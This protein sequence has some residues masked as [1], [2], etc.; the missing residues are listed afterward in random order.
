MKSLSPIQPQT[1][2]TELKNASWLQKARSASHRV[3]PLWSLKNFVA[4]N[5]FVGLVDRPFG[6]VCELIKRVTH[7]S[8]LMDPAWFKS[9]FESGRISRQDLLEAV[10]AAPTSKHDEKE[11]VVDALLRYL[12]KPSASESTRLKVL[13]VSDI[14]DQ[15]HGAHW[16]AAVNEEIAKW[17]AA[18]FDEGQAAWRMPWQTGSLFSAW[19]EAAVMDASMEIQGLKEFREIVES[20]PAEAPE[21]ITRLLEELNVDLDGAED[22]FHRLFMSLPGWSAFV[23]WRVREKAIQGTQNDMM[24][25]LLAIRL[26]Y[27][28]A[29]L[30]KYEPTGIREFWTGCFANESLDVARDTFLHILWHSALERSFQRALLGKLTEHNAEG[31]SDVKVVQAVQAVFCID[32]RSEVMRRSLEAVSPSLE[33]LGFAGFFGLAIEYIPFGKR[34]GTSQC[35]VLLSP[36]FRVK[37]R[38]P[39]AS[40]TV[41]ER[42]L[43]KQQLG[44]RVGHSWRSFKD[45]AV[46]CFSF[47]ESAG[48]ASGWKLLND[49]FQITLPTGKTRTFAPDLNPRVQSCDK[50]EG[51]GLEVGI[52]EEDQV[53]LA[54]GALKNMGLTTRFARLILLCGHGS[55]TKN[56]PY[57]SGLDCGACGGHSGD[58]NARVGAAI[59]NR[60]VVRAALKDKHGICIPERTVFLSGLHDTTT[61]KITLFDTGSVPHSHLDD[62]RNL[63]D[64][65]HQAS[66]LTRQKRSAML[67]IQGTASHRLNSTFRKRSNDWSQVRP[68]WGL[69]GNAAFIAAPRER[70]KGLDLGGRVFLHNYQFEADTTHSTLELIM[71]APMI[72][73]SWINMQYY[74][75]TV[76]NAQW[77]SGNK[78]THNV[79]GTHGVCQGNTGD[80]KVGLPLQSL[81]DG[82]KWIHE[83]LRLTV[84]L[85]A[86]REAI[87]G[88]IARNENV[89]HL[90]DNG[91]LHLLALEEGG[92]KAYRY[93][94]GNRWE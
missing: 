29:L 49:T 66:D 55:N 60:A 36:Q 12:E 94:S 13:T 48:I 78:V 59:L 75:S 2:A 51:S 84:I 3:P 45:S 62:L 37:E 73:A 50:A 65:L 11:R 47:V 15:R 19:G 93:A 61:D 7:D 35:P 82:K 77:G 17:C 25:D 43:R 18:Y 56:N 42:H 23:Q 16:S 72:V 28:L 54:F 5:P 1:S 86:P 32:V 85:E 53:K 44:R 40:P 88:V 52:T 14:V 24:L 80:L 67:G 63:K 64:W 39:N 41:E 30:R 34:Q 22:Y 70:T 91:W 6:E 76:N 71:T 20:L 27:E 31:K 38:I 26:T 89:R 21:A 8:M 9:A 83:P 79:V 10:E 33:T 92:R 90:V 81:H 46:S 4:V 68:E 58:S 57:G 69:A 74:A 87:S